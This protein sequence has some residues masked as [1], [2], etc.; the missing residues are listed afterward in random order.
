MNHSLAG[1]SSH[2]VEPTEAAQGRHMMGVSAHRF[3]T[4]H[5]PGRVIGRE[6]I[7]HLMTSARGRESMEDWNWDSVHKDWAKAVA[8]ASVA[9]EGKD[10]RVSTTMKSLSVAVSS[11]SGIFLRPTPVLVTGLAGAGKTTLIKS[12]GGEVNMD[13]FTSERSEDVEKYDSV[14]RIGRQ[15][16]RVHTVVTPGQD[17]DKRG[18]VRDDYLS[19]S[20]FPSVLIHVVCHGYNKI[21]EFSNQRMLY[22]ELPGG[23]PSTVRDQLFDLKRTEEVKDFSAICARLKEVWSGKTDKTKSIIIAVAKADLYWRER[24]AIH[25]YY[26]PSGAAPRNGEGQESAFCG[27]LRGLV[28]AIGS[29]RLRVAVIPVCSQSRTY[30]FDKVIS[31][32]P[33]DGLD[34][35][36]KFDRSA[37][38][39]TLNNNFLN[40]VGKF[41]AH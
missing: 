2:L 33:F 37:F 19:V 9:A 28:T 17:S 18:N 22:D 4:I 12:L 35:D 3:M 1:P 14:I 27:E 15:K 39:K 20:H 31:E 26:I 40:Q 38:A 32:E 6:Q 7:H 41:C 10:S 25:D 29:S 5:Q 36:N 16:E 21:W 24:D 11:I 34:S 8:K 23:T 13:V 30:E